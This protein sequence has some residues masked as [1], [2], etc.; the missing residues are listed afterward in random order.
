MAFF[1]PWYIFLFI[2]AFDWGFYAHSLISVQSAARA[3]A[4]ATSEN[5]STASNATLACTNA[6]GELK[7]A[8][9]IP[10]TLVTCNALPVVVTAELKTGANSADG[11]DASEVMVAYQTPRLIPIPGLLTKQSTLRRVVQM[12]LRT[13]S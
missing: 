6:L 10:S 2:G 13:G 1:L 9:N 3:A 4:I 11:S 5:S 12:R 7:I 8:S